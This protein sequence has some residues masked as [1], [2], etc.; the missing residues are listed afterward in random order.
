ME[1]FMNPISGI[2]YKIMIILHLFLT[3]INFSQENKTELLKYKLVVKDNNN[4]PV[5]EAFVKI[6]TYGVNGTEDKFLKT[7]LSG[8][9]TGSFIIG[10]SNI[11]SVILFEGKMFYSVEK[12]SFC[13][14]EKIEN[15]IKNETE[16]KDTLVI[17]IYLR[18]PTP[19]IHKFNI[20]VTDRKMNPVEGAIVKLESDLNNL[21]KIESYIQTDVHGRASKIF[22][23]N[24]SDYFCN[25]ELRSEAATSITYSV[26]KD[27]FYQK[28]SDTKIYMYKENNEKVVLTQPSDF[29]EDEFLSL[30][31]YKKLIGSTYNLL[32]SLLLESYLRDCVLN[33][34]SISLESFKRKNYLRLQFTD[35]N[36]YN[37]I[38]LTNYDIAKRIFDEVVRKLLNPLNDNLSKSQDVDGYCVVIKTKSKNIIDEKAISKDLVYKFYLLKTEVTNYKNKDITGQ[39]LIDKSIILLNDERIDLKFQ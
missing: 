11:S 30:K 3:V 22:N 35:V 36:T 14:L 6:T 5:N 27:G 4:F 13:R 29:F 1:K 12:E 8:L 18:K 37:S 2:R 34:N 38:K 16:V 32:N 19:L 10:R 20:I 15:I 31:K 26:L 39:Q 28:S 7:N 9:I 25:D 24:N 33:Y 17:N 21:E 23:Y